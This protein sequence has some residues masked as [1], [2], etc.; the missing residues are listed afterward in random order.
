[1]TT[2]ERIDLLKSKYRDGEG[3][4][5]HIRTHTLEMDL[6]WFLKEE[7]V[8]LQSR[9]DKLESACLWAKDQFK[10]LADEGRYPEF[11]LAENGGEGIMPLINA[12]S[13]EKGGLK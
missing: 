2:Q 1:M 6:L 7:T 11:M 8:D 3:V 9:L 12:L 13:S 5:L 4:P 10:R